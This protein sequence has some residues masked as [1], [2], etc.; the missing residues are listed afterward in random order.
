V[1]FAAL[2]I[3]GAAVYVSPIRDV[4]NLVFKNETYSHIVLIPLVSSVLLVI[5]RKTIFTGT[6]GIFAPGYAICAG[7]LCLYGL[8]CVLKGYFYRQALQY[9]DVPNDYLSL[10]MTG[11]MAWVIGSFIAVY[12]TQAFKKARFALLFLAF[13][14]PIPMFLLEVIVSSLQHASAEVSD[15]IFKLSGASYYR[16]GLVFEFSNVAVQVAEQCSGIRSSLSLLILSMV[17]GFLFL[18]TRSHRSI[19]VFAVFPITVVKNALR[20]MTITLLANQ[21]DSRFLT[22]HWIHTS[23]GIP[24]FAVA[25]TLFIP[26]VWILRMSEVR[27]TNQTDFAST[28]AT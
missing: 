27:R 26:L 15:F 1:C 2:L 8:A 7:G 3:I 13:T 25:L 21:V 18:R 28:S 23:G 20:I 19:L 11:A 5:H 9:Q 22:N 17:T 4:G 14:I 24:F 12:G 16:S 10:C 6:G